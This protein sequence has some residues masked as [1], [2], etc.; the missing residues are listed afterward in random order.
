M[1]TKKDYLSY[2]KQLH[3]VELFMVKEGEDLLKIIDDKEARGL[4]NQLISDEKRHAKI[5]KDMMKLIQ[6]VK[7]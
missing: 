3:S 5:V 7:F 2:L 4:I 6:K 1:F